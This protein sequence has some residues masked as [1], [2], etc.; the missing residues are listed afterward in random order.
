M[1]VGVGVHTRACRHRDL[2]FRM[3]ARG[4]GEHFFFRVEDG[5]Q[6]LQTVADGSRYKSA[7]LPELVANCSKQ[8]SNYT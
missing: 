4:I 6:L 3:Y 2:I 5:L 1:R 7:K 8:L